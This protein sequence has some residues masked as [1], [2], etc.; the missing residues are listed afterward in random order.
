MNILME[1]LRKVLQCIFTEPSES[2]TEE[3]IKN[4]YYTK[5]K[6]AVENGELNSETVADVE[7][8]FN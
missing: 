5:L 6:N 2:D 8:A 1:L 7:K 3:E 4:N